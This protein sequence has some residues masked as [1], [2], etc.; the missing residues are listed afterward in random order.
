MSKPLIGRVVRRLRTEQGVAQQAL[1]ARLGIS[2]SYLN[3]I[4]HDQR[5][6]T[7]AILI[8]LTEALGV[9]IAT[10]SGHSEKA[11]ETS[12]REVFADQ[13]LGSEK[14]PD[15]EVAALA[16]SAPGAARAILA[17]YRAWRV[18]REDSAGLALPSGRRL[19]MPTEETRDFFHDRANHFPA[20]EA[21]TE[22]L[23]QE[24]GATAAGMNHAIAERLRSRH[25][26]RVAVGP[27]DGALRRYDPAAR[28]LA[29]SETLP[30]ESRGFQ[31]AFQLLLLEAGEPV[32]TL[33]RDA[34]PSTPDAAALIRIGLLNY[35]AGALLM[36]YQP[37]HAAARTLRH[38][39]D[40]LAARF[41]V[42]FEQAAHRL[43]TLQREGLRGL[44]FFFLRVDLAGNVDKRFSAAGFPFARF[45]GSCPK[46]VV[47]QAFTT[48]GTLRV[49][50][51]ALPD[52]ARFL[53]FART[54]QGQ[55]RGW[56]DPPP[57]HVVA[58]GCDAAHA[59]DILYAEGMDMKHDPV[60][61]GLSCRLCDR[62][63]CRSRAFPPL[64]HRLT[65]DPNEDGTSPWRF[66]KG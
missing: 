41:G 29:L 10:L 11:M 16:A 6:V 63:D 31:M 8:K 9:D 65:L 30:R 48:P 57:L 27:L 12:L 4:E 46:W 19:L 50:H 36:P 54:V 13:A 43:C 47:H 5:A 55:G 34:A 14:V 3:L 60:G 62:T 35:A 26:V 2:A 61:I 45:G 18:A 56:G 28:L 66:E 59:G 17:L 37:F 23:G 58:M 15:V 25:G 22:T 51:A 1:A 64:D 53:C 38:D 24:L 44:P 49:Q 33:I 42:S 20:L 7:A 21:L 40:A 32:D 52:G 39:L